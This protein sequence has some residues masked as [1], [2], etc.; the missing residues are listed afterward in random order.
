MSLRSGEF[1]RNAPACIPTI[2]RRR[3]NAYTISAAPTQF[4]SPLSNR[5]TDEYGGS[6]E[7]RMRFAIEM[8]D[9]VRA[10][11]PQH[12]PLGMRVSATD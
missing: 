6:T 1:R 10:V 2:T 11:W 9:A 5:R 3:S 12:K 8:F 4:L 7:N